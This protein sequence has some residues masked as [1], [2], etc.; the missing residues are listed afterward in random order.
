MVNLFEHAFGIA[1]TFDSHCDT[2]GTIVI[3]TILQA[4]T[5]RESPLPVTVKLMADLELRCLKDD[6]VGAKITAR[7]LSFLTQSHGTEIPFIV[8]ELGAISA[9]ALPRPAL[10]K[11]HPGTG[12]GA[13]HAV[14]LLIR[15]HHLTSKGFGE[16]IPIGSLAADADE[17]HLVTGGAIALAYLMWI[18]TTDPL[19]DAIDKALDRYASKWRNR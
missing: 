9:T 12:V 6:E 10:G 5:D 15:G 19:P 8:R 7:L 11:L 3:P 14:T 4:R 16:V 17:Q 13:K 2:L 1:A 18:W